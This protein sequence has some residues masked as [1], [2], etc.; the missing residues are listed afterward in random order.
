MLNNNIWYQ[1]TVCKQMI[2]NM[3]KNKVAY[4]LFAYRS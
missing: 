2:S 3:F 1:L 4:K